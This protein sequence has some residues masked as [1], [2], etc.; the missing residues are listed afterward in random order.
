MI[1]F[2]DFPLRRKLTLLLVFIVTV[3]LLLTTVATIV[4]EIRTTKTLLVRQFTT[5]ANVLAANSAAALSVDPGL[6]Q[7]V[8]NDLSVEPTI[9]FVAT[10]VAPAEPG[11]LARR[12]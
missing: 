2:R 4:I 10:K 8:L 6:S 11:T 3:A 12:R 7:P 9:V 5:L 1:A